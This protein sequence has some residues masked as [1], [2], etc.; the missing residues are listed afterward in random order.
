M[1][2]ADYAVQDVRPSV[3]PSVTRRYCVDTAISNAQSFFPPL[4]PHHSSSSTLNAMALFQQGPPKGDV[5]C[6]GL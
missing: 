5:E 2:S 6:T 4:G 1:C 3:R